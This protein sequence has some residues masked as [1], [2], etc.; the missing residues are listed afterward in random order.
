MLAATFVARA[1]KKRHVIDVSFFI[2]RTRSEQSRLRTA[3]TEAT[4]TRAQ[5]YS[6]L[7]A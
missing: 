5:C 7:E 1:H 4:S 6:R 3:R 2:V